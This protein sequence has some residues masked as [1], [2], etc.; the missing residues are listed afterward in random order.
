MR[1]TAFLADAGYRV[2]RVTNAE[3]FASVEG[4]LET[5]LAALEGRGTL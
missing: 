1:R 3:V 4:V 5:I 2:V